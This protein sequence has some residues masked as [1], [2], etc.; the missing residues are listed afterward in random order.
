MKVWDAP[1]K[2]QSGEARGH[3]VDSSKKGRGG[4]L[5]PSDLARS[6]D[7]FLLPLWVVHPAHPAI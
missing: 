1:G 7:L 6:L 5:G 4:M 2:V 3:P